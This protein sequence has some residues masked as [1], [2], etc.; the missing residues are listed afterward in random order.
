[1]TH[2]ALFCS[3]VVS[4]ITSYLPTADVLSLVM[5]GNKLLNRVLVDNSSSC[6]VY[7]ER[8][9]RA[10]Y[11]FLDLFSNTKYVYIKPQCFLNRSYDMNDNIERV[12]APNTMIHNHTFGSRLQYMDAEQVVD[13]H[14]AGP[15]EY[16]KTRIIGSLDLYVTHVE[17]RNVLVCSRIINDRVR[18]PRL[19]EVT[20][21]ICPSRP[22]VTELKVNYICPPMFNH[23]PKCSS[24]GLSTH[25]VFLDHIEEVSSEYDGVRILHVCNV[26]PNFA[27]NTIPSSVTK[28]NLFVDDL[29]EKE[30]YSIVS[31]LPE[32]VAVVDITVHKLTTDL[33]LSFKH[34]VRTAHIRCKWDDDSAID[35]FSSVHDKVQFDSLFIE[36]VG[37]HHQSK[38]SKLRVVGDYCYYIE[39]FRTAIFERIGARK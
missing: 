10:I 20:V 21:P 23:L 6:L 27:F 31:E 35:A 29:S 15:I 2:R 9:L 22:L 25:T 37:R 4:G 5:C 38:T 17:L 13:C 18:F 8:D 33:L 12:V 14:F 28:M 30:I 19:K 26:N 24:C 11:Q 32:T 7:T 34:T 3:D 16:Y 39:D 36:F 1:M